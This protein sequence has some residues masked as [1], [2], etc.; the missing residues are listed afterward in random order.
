MLQAGDLLG[1]HAGRG[2]PLLVLLRAQPDGLHVRFQPAL[3][4][5]Q[6]GLG[7]LGVHQLGTQ[8]GCPLLAV[9]DGGQLRQ[10]PPSVRQLVEGGVHLLQIEQPELY[11]RIGF[12]VRHRLS[13]KCTLLVPV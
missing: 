11:E 7:R 10:R 5:G 3:L 9:G 6:V 2:H 13:T 1:R 8:V 4:A 12:H